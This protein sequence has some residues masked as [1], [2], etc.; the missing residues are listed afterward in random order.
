[1]TVPKCPFKNRAGKKSTFHTIAYPPTHAPNPPTVRS[2]AP[3]SSSRAKGPSRS[4]Y[5]AATVDPAPQRKYPT[6]RERGIIPT[7]GRHTLQLDPKLTGS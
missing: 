5:A 7:D 6:R 1:M 2:P 4:A 3:R